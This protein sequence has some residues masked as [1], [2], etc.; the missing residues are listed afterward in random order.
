MKSTEKKNIN[1]HFN[2]LEILNWCFYALKQLKEF[3]ERK[4]FLPPKIEK[5]YSYTSWKISQ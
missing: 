4:N 3:P 5:I 1:Y 2:F